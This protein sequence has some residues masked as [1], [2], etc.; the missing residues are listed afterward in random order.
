MVNWRRTA[1]GTVV[2][3]KRKGQVGHPQIMPVVVYCPEPKQPGEAHEGSEPTEV[4]S[5]HIGLLLEAIMLH[6]T[7]YSQEVTI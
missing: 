7:S 2:A 6:H 4:R 5:I 3:S 1:S